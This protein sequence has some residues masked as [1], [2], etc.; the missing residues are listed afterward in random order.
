MVKTDMECAIAWYS[1]QINKWDALAMDAQNKGLAGHS[2]YAY[3]QKGIWEE[4]QNRMKTEMSL[5][6]GDEKIQDT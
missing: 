2:A 1:H 4:L 3:K 5:C 6:I